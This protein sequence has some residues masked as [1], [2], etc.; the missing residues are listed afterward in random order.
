MFEFWASLGTNFIRK[1][2]TLKAETSVS[3]STWCKVCISADKKYTFFGV[4]FT[5]NSGLREPYLLQ[6]NNPFPLLMCL[7][8]F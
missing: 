3:G 7:V 5:F 2:C 4:T 1:T 8:Q 6:I